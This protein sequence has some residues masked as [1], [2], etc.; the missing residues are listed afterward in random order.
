MEQGDQIPVAGFRGAEG[1]IAGNGEN[2]DA[3][4]VMVD[5]QAGYDMKEK[6]RIQVADDAGAGEGKQKRHRHGEKDMD[7]YVFIIPGDLF[8][9]RFFTSDTGEETD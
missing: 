7:V 5:V 9:D 1:Q 6:V 8:T 2:Q 3:I 4:Q